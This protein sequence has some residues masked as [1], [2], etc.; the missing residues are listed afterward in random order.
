MG[1]HIKG[2]GIE[3]LDNFKYSGQRF[4]DQRKECQSLSELL[5]TDE[6]SIPDGFTKYVH[7]TDTWYRYHSENE[8]FEKT[9]KWRTVMHGREVLSAE[10]LYAIV[11]AAG[12]LLFG[13]KR[14]GSIY[15]P[16]GIPVEVQRRFDELSGLKLTDSDKWL[17]GVCDS[18][19]NLLFGIDNHGKLFGTCGITLDGD[20]SGI[21]LMESDN[22]LFA[23]NDREGN[24]LFGIDRHGAVVSNKGMSDE[25]RERFKELQGLKTIKSD[26][27][28]FALSDT[29][30][31]LLFGI[32][33]EGEI[34]F[35]R[36]II[37]V[38]TWEEYEH[39]PTDS[40]ALYLIESEQGTLTGAYY[41][42]RALNTGE[43]YNF[44]MEDNVLVYRGRMSVMPKIAI[45][46]K[47]MTLEVEYPSNYEG[48]IFENVDGLLMLR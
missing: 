31:R 3:I 8:E 14:D 11:D 13:I 7:D 9:G 4:L 34:V 26:N 29:S 25:V 39:Q 36:G 10:Y 38:V 12:N 45:N 48:P 37:K 21:N 47:E 24:L 27:W 28:L 18:L 41:Q 6:T 15:E 2:G 46:H 1:K 43:E 42:G 22:Y 17:F 32:T 33:H 44:L 5:A 40:N 30:D 35:S 19:G 20:E 16:K 23:I